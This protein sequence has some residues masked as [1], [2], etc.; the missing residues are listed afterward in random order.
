MFKITIKAVLLT[1]LTINMSCNQNNSEIVNDYYLSLNS[2]VNLVQVG[3]KNYLLDSYTAPK[4][5]Y[6]QSGVT[7]E[8]I[9]YIS[10][11]NKDQKRIY[12][13]NIDN[14]KI[15]KTI[16]LAN[17]ELKSYQNI[18]AYNIENP[19]SI[20][21]FD[22]V[23]NEILLLNKDLEVLSSISTIDYSESKNFEWTLKFPQYFA[24]TSSPFLSYKNHVFFM[25]LYPWAIE[26]TMLSKFKLSHFFTKKLDNTY[27][28]HNYPDAIYGSKF[29]WDDPIYNIPYYDFNFK[30]ETLVISFPI[31][32]NLYISKNLSNN[33][34]KVFGGSNFSSTIKSIGKNKSDDKNY[35][36]KMTENIKENNLYGAIKYDPYRNIY[37]RFIRK[38]LKEKNTGRNWKDKTLGVIVLDEDFNYLGE[39]DI[40]ILKDWNWENSFVNKQGLY[41]EHLDNINYDETYLRFKIFEIQKL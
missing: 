21:I 11:L 2:T 36:L 5:T 32:H 15:V 25:G 39:T 40:G 30:N 4:P 13:Y 17:E 1:L 10:F 8:N 23:E 12:I 22:E 7:S 38:S 29:D 41:I 9:N 33:L 16:N 35:D 34:I 31:S 37:Y 27:L 26:D 6:I 28:L 24:N 20:Y 3:E 19:D 14:E 18:S